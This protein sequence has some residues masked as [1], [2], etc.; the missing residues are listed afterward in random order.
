MTSREKLI[1]I[2]YSC[3]IGF[4]GDAGL[5]FLTKIMNM[6]GKTGWGLNPYFK[7]HGTVESLF[8][9]GGMMAIFYIIY[10]FIFNLPV[11]YYYLALYGVILDYI[12]RVTMLFPSLVGYYNHLNYFWSAFWGAIPMI[13]PLLAMNVINYKL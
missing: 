11:S 13:L 12:F 1:L 8:I 2:S 4:L 3:I 9:A 6:G 5:Q 10:F 7:Q